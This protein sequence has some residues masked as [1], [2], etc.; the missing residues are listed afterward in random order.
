MTAII[1]HAYLDQVIDRAHEAVVSLT[2]VYPAF[3]PHDDAILN[4]AIG[5]LGKDNATI[6]SDGV[7]ALLQTKIVDR[8]VDPQL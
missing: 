4:V 3:G 6:L 7:L 8:S 2:G 5:M 1:D